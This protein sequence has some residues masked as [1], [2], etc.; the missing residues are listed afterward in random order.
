MNLGKRITLPANGKDDGEERHQ[1][2]KALVQIS[3]HN[4][5]LKKVQEKE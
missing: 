2:E 4:T 1:F 3:S 5:Q